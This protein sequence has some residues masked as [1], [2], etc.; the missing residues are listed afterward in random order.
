MKRAIYSPC[1]VCK[2]DPERPLIWQIKAEK[3][4]HD[5]KGQEIRYYNGF[6]EMFGL[7]VFYVPYF[8]HPDP[9]VKRKTGLLAPDFGTGGNVGGHI[10]VPYYI[11]LDKDKDT[12]I[13]PIYTFDE[14][15]VFSGEYRQRFDKGEM[16]FSGSI[17]EENDS[18]TG[19]GISVG[20]EDEIRGHYRAKGAYHFDETWR[21]GVDSARAT[22]RTYL[23]KYNF[24]GLN[25]DVLDTDVYVEGFRERTYAAANVY[26]F[27]D[28]RSG[29][30]PDQ[31]LIAPLV[32]YHHQSKPDQFGGRI[33]V[34]SDFRYLYRDDGPR[35]Q[36]IS[37]RPEY[38]ISR[39]TDFG[40]VGTFRTSL[41]AD[42]YNVD[43]IDN[44]TVST[45]V[46][47]SVTGRLLPRGTV[48][49]RYPFVRS[50]GSVRQLVEPVAM[51][52]ATPNGGNPTNIPD[53]DSVVYEADD[54]NLLSE[55]RL[56]GGDRVESGQRIAYG[57]RL[58][59][60]GSKNGRTTAFIG[61]SYRFS[62]D[63]DLHDQ[64]LVEEDF[65]DIV[66]RIELQPNRY[67]NILYRF[68]FA[69]DKA[70]EPQ[71]NDVTFTLGPD[72]YKLSGSYSFVAATPQFEERE[73]L[74]LALS[75]QITD[76][77][78]VRLATQQDL[79][80]GQSLKH[81]GLV[82]YQDE[83]ITFDVLGTRSFF[84]DEDVEPSDSV[85]FRIRFKNLGEVSTSAG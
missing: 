49:V 30:R 23:R 4:E 55:D 78:S 18:T 58:G 19:N 72:A 11:V 63:D 53:E 56:P 28:L 61:Q 7:P 69:A 36:R 48:E 70:F 76:H 75:T 57:V 25:E 6:M 32:Q 5:E 34:A 67:A 9:T 33:G 47:S 10:R 46:D 83:C 82:R 65:S 38:E 12:T 84:E 2:E 20:D 68:A 41:T 15:L 17:T 73:E 1:E 26:S 29:D 51:V 59:A 64:N 31:P 74:T 21:A 35:T 62:T 71:R 77:W 16:E 60:Y 45:N 66:G 52:T 40:L 50:T 3:I 54:T 37:F 24:F 80:A 39:T 13:S 42:L 22:D 44:P 85:L 8:S 81:S 79:A 14:G 27:Q 43:Q